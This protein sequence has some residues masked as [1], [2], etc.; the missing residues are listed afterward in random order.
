MVCDFTVLC[1]PKNSDNA[2]K[3]VEGLL[4]RYPNLNFRLQCDPLMS[5]G[6]VIMDRDGRLIPLKDVGTDV[7]GG[8]E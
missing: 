2:Q 7:G 5:G 1:H 4:D 8:D 6:I 3:L